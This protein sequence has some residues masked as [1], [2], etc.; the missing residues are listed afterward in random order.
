MKAVIYKGIRDIVVEERPEPF[1]GDNDVIV[2]NIRSGICGSDVGAYLYGTMAS[3]IFPDREFGHEMVG[4]VY[5]TGKNITGIKPGLRVWVNPNTSVLNPWDSDMAG[6][7]SQYTVVHNAK[8]NDNLYPLP[9][10]LS[11]DDAVLIEPFAVGTHGKNRACCKKDTSVLIYG[12]GTIGLCALNSLI[13]Q[14]NK[15]IAV[16]DISH[17]RL[18]IAEKMGAVTCNPLETNYRDFLFSAFGETKSNTPVIIKTGEGPTD[19]E[20]VSGKAVNA[21]VVIDCAGSHNIAG[22]FLSFAKPHAT[23]VCIAVQKKEI[24]VN[25]RQIMSTEAHIIGSRGYTY[26]DIQEV[27][28]NLRQKN[29][30]ITDIITHHFK[31]SD[32][33]KAFE[34]ASDPTVAIKVVFDMETNG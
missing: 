27:I 8:L 24:A 32:A 16:L 1:C 2:Q 28:E 33:Q 31:L 17:D 29:T 14:G 20:L 4:F 7:F 15:N 12:A 18:K 11:F 9:D 3:G 26:A 6:A 13:A 21:D 22:D 23:L 19:I 5:K 30:R 10:D 25:F 34:T